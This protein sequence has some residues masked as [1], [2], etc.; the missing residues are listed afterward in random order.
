MWPGAD[1]AK[2]GGSL[3]RIDAGVLKGPVDGVE[4]IWFQGGEPYFDVHVELDGAGE[5]VWIQ[6]SIRGRS[7][8]WD[9]ATPKLVTGHTN[10]RA[11]EDVAHPGS[12]MIRNDARAD[13]ELVRFAVAILSARED[14]PLL[15]RCAALVARGLA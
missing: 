15:G 6:L 5:I 14:E 10:E 1:P 13:E 12:K 2:L 7:I 3:R 9:A 11:I 8:T 4:R